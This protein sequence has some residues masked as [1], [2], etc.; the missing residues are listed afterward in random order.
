MTRQV[1]AQELA[2]RLGVSI[3]T[4]R[5]LIRQGRLRAEMVEGD[6]R[7]DPSDLAAFLRD[8][9]I[10]RLRPQRRGDVDIESDPGDRG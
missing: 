10:P 6:Y 9:E 4:V 1:S 7:I 5:R 2:D 3:F 8:R